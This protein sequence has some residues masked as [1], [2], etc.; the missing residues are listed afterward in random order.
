LAG[1]GQQ[2]IQYIQVSSG[3]P[4]VTYNALSNSAH[5]DVAS[6]KVI[7]KYTVY[8]L[9]ASRIGNLGRFARV[10]VGAGLNLEST[11]MIRTVIADDFGSAHYTTDIA[12]VNK[13]LMV[14]E[15]KAG[16]I[17]NIGTRVQLQ[18]T[19]VLFFSPSSMFGKSYLIKQR[20]AGIGLDAMVVFKLF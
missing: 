19:P 15:I 9:E 17:E 12:L 5:Q 8:S 4:V 20:Y 10:R 14:T 11:R 7:F 6:D 16:I 3:G 1:V 18:V 13:R 2:R